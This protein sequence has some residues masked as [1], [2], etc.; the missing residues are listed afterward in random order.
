MSIQLEHHLVSRTPGQRSPK[1]PLPPVAPGPRH[2]TECRVH[3]EKEFSPA[4]SHPNM[5][6]HCRVPCSDYKLPSPNQEQWPHLQEEPGRAEGRLGTTLLHP[7]LWGWGAAGRGCTEAPEALPAPSCPGSLAGSPAVSGDPWGQHR[8]CGLSTGASSSACA[9]C[10]ADGDG[11]PVKR[12]PAAVTGPSSCGTAVPV[13][14]RP[15]LDLDTPRLWGGVAWTRG[16]RRTWSEQSWPPG[17]PHTWRGPG[18]HST[19]APRQAPSTWLTW[20]HRDLSS[21]PC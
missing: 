21:R 3:S 9:S 1:C 8:G 16:C 12:R 5:Y 7:R 17:Q 6:S 20:G 15:P 2:C 18:L 19:G 10:R 13:L 11:E 4:L 14:L